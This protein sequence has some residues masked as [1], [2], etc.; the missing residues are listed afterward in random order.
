MTASWITASTYLHVDVRSFL[1][2]NGDGWGDLAGLTSKLDYLQALGIGAIRV[3][4][5]MPTDFAYGGTMITDYFDIEPRFGTLADFDRLLA[6][7]HRRGIH[8]IIGYSPYTRHADHPHWQASRDPRHPDHAEFAGFFFWGSDDL[9]E[10]TPA[11]MGRWEW[12]EVRQRYYYT[13]WFTLDGR[14]CPETNALCPR[15][16]QENERILR[17]WLDRGVDG[18]WVDTATAGTFMRHEDHVAF[19]REFNG[20]VHGYPERFTLAEGGSRSVAGTID[21]DGFDTFWT[22]QGRRIPSYATVFGP[23]G[24]GILAE[25]PPGQEWH[26]LHEALTG[27]YNLPRGNQVTHQYQ[28]EQ[29]LDFTNEADTARAKQLHALA[30]T[31]PLPPEAYTGTEC[32]LTLRHRQQGSLYELSPL[33]WQPPDR[34]PHYGFTTGT[35]WTEV[36]PHGYPVEATVERQLADPDSVLNTFARLARLR[37]DNSALQANGPVG[38][39]YARVPTDDP[40]CGYAFVRRC[41]ATGQLMLAVFNLH[42]D[43]RALALDFIRSRRVAGFLGSRPY[44]LAPRYGRGP[45]IPIEAGRC[46]VPLSAHG[47]EVFELTATAPAP[48]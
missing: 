5:V 41:P 44:H 36:N 30:L 11:R 27:W 38:E 23:L 2:S 24:R 25:G 13:I 35:P 31:L 4:N 19:S 28:F 40:R 8:L 20:I 39:T 7:A 33:L 22:N 16:R 45:A 46:R 12:D 37:R 1:D 10:P 47:F 15:L 17:F 18:F 21:D 14:P 9:N 26:G 3:I 43:W 34:A 29:P 42:P 6:E 32:G 48:A